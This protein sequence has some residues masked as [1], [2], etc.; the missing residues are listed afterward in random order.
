MAYTFEFLPHLAGSLERKA[1]FSFY[2]VKWNTYGKWGHFEFQCNLPAPFHYSRE[3][4]LPGV[5]RVFIVDFTLRDSFDNWDL[6]RLTLYKQ[7][8]D[9]ILT[10]MPEGI[11]LIPENFLLIR[12]R[13][14]FTREQRKEIA[15]SLHFRFRSKDA[16]RIL[17]DD[18]FD[19]L[20]LLSQMPIQ[21]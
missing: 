12:L 4:E 14:Q 20:P 17:L 5:K 2:E 19:I 16:E 6:P 11:F 13:L 15:Q 7:F 18:S 9:K 3:L 1:D 10:D 8:K 21:L